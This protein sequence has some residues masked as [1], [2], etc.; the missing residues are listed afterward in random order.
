MIEIIPGDI[1]T[2][3]VDAIVNAANEYL[4]AGGGVC[5]VIHKAAGSKLEEECKALGGCEVGQAK[6]TSA[7][8]LPAKYVIHTVGPRWLNGQYN[9]AELLASCYKESMRIANQ[10]D[11]KSISFPVIS[12]G[13]YRFPIGDACSIAIATVSEALLGCTS[14]ER[15]VFACVQREVREHLDIAIDNYGLPSLDQL[16]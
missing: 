7:Y 15:V 10:H 9:E 8:K 4:I 3:Q 16:L 6:I 12:S 13:T 1:T 2:L 5:G 14:I 11:I